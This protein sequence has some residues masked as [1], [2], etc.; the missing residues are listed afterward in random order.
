MNASITNAG[1]WASSAMR[2]TV[3]GS[4][5]YVQTGLKDLESAAMTVTKKAASDSSGSWDENG[6]TEDKFWLPSVT[7]VFDTGDNNT[8]I[9]DNFKNEGS[10][11][12]WFEAIGVNAK[13]GFDTTNAAIENLWKIRS[14]DNRPADASQPAWR[15][16]SPG[17]SDSSSFG[18][19]DNFG[20]LHEY[21]ADIA[22]SI[23][24]AFAM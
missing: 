10:Q 16:R 5:G 23:V 18:A 8:L 3:L 11:Y 13:N 15:L 19:S 9:P 24:P 20:Q 12:V 14:G 4:D 1:G 7:E 6:T 17:I 21:Y 2:T 22:I